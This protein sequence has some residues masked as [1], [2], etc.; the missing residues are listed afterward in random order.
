MERWV[1]IPRMAGDDCPVVAAHRRQERDR[2]HQGADSDQDGLQRDHVP[3]DR[4]LVEDPSDQNGADADGPGPRPQKFG[5][6][7]VDN[8]QVADDFAVPAGERWTVREVDVT[9]VYFNGS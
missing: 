9:G 8:A 6:L 1:T 4:E 5:V 2:R 7:D 3:N